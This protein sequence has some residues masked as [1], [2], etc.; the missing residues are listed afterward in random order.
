MSIPSR[1]NTDGAII[2]ILQYSLASVKSRNVK[3]KSRPKAL[4]KFDDP[5]P[6]YLECFSFILTIK[7]ELFRE[8][9]NSVDVHLR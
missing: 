1:S 4:N 8:K 2:Q 5:A 6:Q 9:I 3:V 7:P